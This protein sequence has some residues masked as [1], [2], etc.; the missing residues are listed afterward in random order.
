MS[1]SKEQYLEYNILMQLPCCIFWKDKDG[2]FLGCNQAF[3][4]SMG[5][6]SPFEIIG[7][8]DYDLS[9]PDEL[10]NQYRNCDKE[11]IETKQSKTN[12]EESQVLPDGSQID[13]L[14]SKVPLKDKDGQVIGVLGFYVDITERKNIEKYY[15]Y[16]KMKYEDENQAKSKFIVDLLEQ[17]PSYIFWKD[18]NCVYLGCNELFAKSAGLTSSKEIIGKTDFDLVWKDQADLYTADDQEVINSRLPKLNIEEPQTTS[19]GQKI[20]LLTS[21]VPLFDNKDN[22]VGIL[23]VYVDITERKQI[24]EDLRMAKIA[25]EIA[26]R[27][28]TEF[29]ANMSHDIRTPLTGILGLIQEM[30][31][32]ADDTQTSI[33]QPMLT[34]EEEIKSNHLSL[35]TEIIKKVQENSHLLIGAADELLQLLNEILET[36]RLESGSAPEQ[37]E[38]FNLRELVNHNINLMQPIAHHKQLV[39]NAE[40]DESIPDYFSGHRNYLDRTLL[41]LLSNALK[42]TDKGFVKLKIELVEKDIS[43][44]KNGDRINLKVSVQDTGIGIP[45]DKFSTIFEHFSRLSPSYQGLYKGAGLGLYTVQRYIEAMEA[46]IKLESKVGEGSCFILTIPLAI[47]DHSDR[48]KISYRRFK[49]NKLDASDP[50]TKFDGQVSILIVEDNSLAAKSVQ[51]NLKHLNMG[52]SDVAQNGKQAISMA[53]EHNYDLVLMDIG[54][55]DIDGIEVTRQIRALNIDVPIL[56]LTGHGSEPEIKGEALAA[57]MQDVFV[58]PLHIQKLKSVLQLYAYDSHQE[59][60]TLKEIEQS[61]NRS[62]IID[63]EATILNMNGDENCVRELL[64]ILAEDLKITQ[65]TLAQAYAVQDTQALCDELHKVQGGLAYLILPQLHKS[66][67]Q[68]HREVKEEPHNFKQ[69]DNSYKQLQ[70]AMQ[71]FWKVWEIESSATL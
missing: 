2:V 52:Q 12:F 47:S 53:Q 9:F 34:Q 49:E 65:K 37:T 5:Y 55:P 56:A 46:D 38:A 31:N 23:G 64:A 13:L 61:K 30:I 4:T 48:E 40:I 7:K 26:S 19:D 20:V 10:S 69:I 22:V 41:N 57:G 24:E 29:I 17:L 25:A 33:N 60:L 44:Y 6:S 32:T 36:M 14:T 21:K 18:K 50:K 70:E 15:Q 16:E 51:A 3:A 39:L 58:K 28:K 45:K 54:L 35:L 63:W 27:S 43:K 11:I 67:A 62:E 8:T 66:L 1:L 59:D 68:F 42:F 71:T